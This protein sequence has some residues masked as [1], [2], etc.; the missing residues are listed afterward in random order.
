MSANRLRPELVDRAALQWSALGV[1]LQASRESAV[2]DVE[3][4]IALTAAVGTSDARVWDGA[5]AWC[6]RH[7][8]FVNSA[9]LKGVVGEM[10]IAG[11]ELATFSTAARLAGAPPWSQAAEIEPR[12]PR[13]QRRDDLV[14]VGPTRNGARLLWFLR[15]TFGVNARADIVANMAGRPGSA[16]TVLEL[17]Q[18]I[19]FTKRNAAV[20]LDDLVL[21]GVVERLGPSTVGRFR[22][23]DR[24]GLLRWLGLPDSVEYPDWVAQFTVGLRVSTFLDA[25]PSS[26]RVRAIE[27]R[28]IVTGLRSSIERAGLTG[29]DLRVTGPAFA[30]EFD[31]WVGLL[32]GRFGGHGARDVMTARVVQERVRRSG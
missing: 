2:V 32:A 13:A 28:A 6:G 11:A 24:P 8:R 20:A 12:T 22:L 21:S 15:A 31:T 25:D 18:L 16:L 10:G 5:V 29:P 23:R 17:A 27:A 9:R 14:I 4:L 1:A 26:P 19:R 7:G 30:E 3:A